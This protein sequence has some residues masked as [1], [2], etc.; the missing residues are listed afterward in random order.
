MTEEDLKHD[1]GC[2]M[3][4]F[5]VVIYFM[6]SYMAGGLAFQDASF[7]GKLWRGLFFPVAIFLSA[8][9]YLSRVMP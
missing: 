5:Y 7:F 6:L 1:N 9:E 4:I 3:A 2:I 8:S